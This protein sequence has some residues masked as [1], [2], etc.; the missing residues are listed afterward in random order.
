[1]A[2]RHSTFRDILQPDNSSVAS[3]SWDGTL[4]DWATIQHGD[5]F[6]AGDRIFSYG[7]HGKG[8][9][10]AL[11]WSPDGNF[12]ATAGADQT[13]QISNGSDGTPSKPFF[14]AHQ[15]KQH[16]NPVRSAAWSPDGNFIASGDTD[17][18]VYVWRV[19]GRKT[20]FVYRG[21]KKTVNA[22][23]WSPDG[24]KIASASADNTVHVWQPIG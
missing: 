14:T 15:S 11:T 13:V 6:N 7:G 10:Y 12:I 3:G 9:V 1:M 21:H 23:A 19:A 8:E 2:H 4:R 17:G 18:N 5:H 22:L 16:V 24:K 20:V